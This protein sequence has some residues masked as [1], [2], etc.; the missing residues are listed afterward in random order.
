MSFENFARAHG[1]LLEQVI[2]DGRWH[3]TKTED[4]PRRRNGAYLFDG[5]RGVVINFA[6]MV[7]GVA[8]REGAK[9]QEIDRKAI[10]QMQQKNR[11][12]EGR[13]QAAARA[14]AE[15]MIAR[16]AVATHPYLAA[17]GFPA[18]TGLVL[19]GELL[20][21]MREFS[22]YRQVNSIQKIKA[23]G[24]KLFL[25]GGKAKGSVYF[26]GPAVPRERWLCEGYATGLSIRAAIRSLYRDAQVIVCFSSGNLAHVGRVVSELSGKAYVMADNDKSEAGAKAAKETGLSWGMPPEVG[27]DANDLHRRAGVS[28]LKELIRDITGGSSAF[29]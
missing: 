17:K 20:I 8:W 23:D 29:S 18:E 5:L 12:E 3:R 19:D 7:H 14:T 25:P 24:T 21:P 6:T 22:L 16:A 27:E 26:I 1:L 9:A 2:P 11:E 15:G 4:K 10:R 28:V 13:R